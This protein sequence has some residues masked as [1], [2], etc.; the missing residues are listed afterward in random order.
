MLHLLMIFMDFNQ[1]LLWLNV[2][3]TQCVDD[4]STDCLVRTRLHKQNCPEIRTHRDVAYIG[5]A[6]V[7]LLLICAQSPVMCPMPGSGPQVL[8]ELMSLLAT[9]S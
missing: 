3:L 6:E 2:Q 1:R 7:G 5:R 8:Y 9:V 4:C